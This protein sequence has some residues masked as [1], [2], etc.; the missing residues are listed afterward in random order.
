M[1]KSKLTMA[2]LALLAMSQAQAADP[3]STK[4]RYVE[5]LAGAIALAGEC[6]KWV[7][8]PVATTQLMNFM[9][10]TIADISPDGRYWPT[11]DKY[12][13]ITGRR[14]CE[15]NFLASGQARPLAGGEQSAPKE[16]Q[17]P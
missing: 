17:P 8:D 10:I 15:I 11:I 2:T 4:D 16:D 14:G 3:T 9:H 1:T 5:N 13:E 7:V 6:P 12:N